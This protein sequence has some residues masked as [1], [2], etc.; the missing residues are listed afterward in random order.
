MIGG[1]V[2]AWEPGCRVDTLIRIAVALGITLLASWLVLLAY[3]WRAR[4]DARRASEAM[5]LLPDTIRLL[6]GIA[7]DPAIRWG[8]RIRL[9]LLLAYLAFPIDLVPDFIPVIGYADDVV[10]VCVVLRS[11]VHR[12][13]PDAVRRN[14]PG[15]HE[16]LE[17]IWRIARLPGD[18]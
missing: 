10:I 16:G 2:R 8:V 15:T 6:R 9:W 17:T 7:A 14:W 5:R 13:G 3:L 11:V 4:P 1:E 18:P 12:A